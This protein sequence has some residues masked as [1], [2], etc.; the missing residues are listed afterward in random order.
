MASG[1]EGQH[2]TATMVIIADRFI[3]SMPEHATKVAAAVADPRPAGDAPS[4]PSDT[5]RVVDCWFADNLHGSI[6]ARN[7]D[8]YAHAFQAKEKLKALLAKRSD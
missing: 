3:G 2:H 7:V 5:D 6:I 1:A 4:A 8:A